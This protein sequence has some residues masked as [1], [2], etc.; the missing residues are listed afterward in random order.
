MKVE[1]GKVKYVPLIITLETRKEATLMDH[2]LNCG[3]GKSL[4]K[5]AEEQDIDAGEL[6]RFHYMAW[7]KF[8][9]L[10]SDC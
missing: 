6:N 3:T 8:N 4:I 1:K 2:I 5:Y 7:E 9:A 10:F